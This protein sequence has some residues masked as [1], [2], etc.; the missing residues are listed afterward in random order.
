MKESFR[1]NGSPAN[2]ARTKLVKKGVS[3]WKVPLAEV[4]REMYTVKSL[5]ASGYSFNENA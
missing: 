5:E 4:K 2:S 3:R 1:K